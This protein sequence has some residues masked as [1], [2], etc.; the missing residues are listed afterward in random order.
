VG[1]AIAALAG[2]L[3]EASAFAAT[4]P[5]LGHQ[6]TPRVIRA[7]LA[8][9]LTPLL[10]IAGPQPEVQNLYI[11]IVERAITGAAF[12][13]CAA[14]VANAVIAAGELIDTALGSPPFLER[15]AMSGPIAR[16]YQI[17]F[18]ATLLQSGGLTMLIERL[19]QAGATLP[20]HLL[21]WHELVALGGASFGSSLALA[22]PSL[23][24]QA[25]ATIV[26][27]VLARAAPALNGMIFSGSLAP[28]SV[29]LALAVGAVTLRAQ[30]LELAH[31]AIRLVTGPSS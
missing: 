16:V 14:V 12:G 9:W 31:G 8:L 20:S 13:L 15:P 5:L 3:A 2:A 23:L 21:S 29:L 22:G 26:A 1:S 18:A 27:G 7:V 11:V 6:A 24:A 10:A 17:A 28:A 4:V 30:L 25:L 19:A